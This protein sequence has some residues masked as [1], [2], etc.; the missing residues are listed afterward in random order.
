LNGEGIQLPR[1][2]AWVEPYFQDFFSEV[3]QDVLV[4]QLQ[5]SL[6]TIGDTLRGAA[7]NVFQAL[8]AIS[9]GVFNFLLIL[10]LTFFM[11]VD[12]RGIDQ[13][14]LSLFPSRYADYISD[15]SS[16]IKEKV[17]HWLRAQI[18]LG[19]VIG[20]M[21]YIGFLILGVEFG[22]TLAI[23][24][25]IMEVVPY[26]G[27]FLAW[28]AAVP[29]VLNQAPILVLWVTVMFLI[30]QRLENDILVPL[31]MK[32]A[33]GLSPILVLFAMLVGFEFMGVVGLILSIPV[34]ST[35]SIFVHDY[36]SRAK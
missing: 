15:K 9:N 16:A 2:L 11:V 34:A 8:I 26:V 25:G 23:F 33:T 35:V 21:A 3:N 1:F 22:A 10:V 7:G 32:Q 19:L 5:N 30:I 12:E 4:Q 28:V 24:A 20:V 14:V 6:A 27:P 17:G 18:F 13:F 31:I 29:I 36:T